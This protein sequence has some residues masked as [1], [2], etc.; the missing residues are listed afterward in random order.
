MERRQ[1]ER[2]DLLKSFFGSEI[3]VALGF[4]GLCSLMHLRSERLT[5]PKSF[6]MSLSRRKVASWKQETASQ[7]GVVSIANYGSEPLA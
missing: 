2:L 3:K 1:I 7:P 5:Q 6:K 4:C